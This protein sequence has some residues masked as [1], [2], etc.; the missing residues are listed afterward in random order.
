MLVVYP[1][2]LCPCWWCIPTWYT[3]GVPYLSPLPLLVVCPMPLV[4]YAWTWPAGGMP[5]AAGEVCLHGRGLRLSRRDH[6]CTSGRPHLDPCMMHGCP[7][8]IKPSD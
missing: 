5:Y 4:R 6:T 1:M 7:S 2:P 8:T 3:G